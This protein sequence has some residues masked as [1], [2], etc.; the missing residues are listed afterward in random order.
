VAVLARVLQELRIN[1]YFTLLTFFWCLAILADEVGKG[2]NILYLLDFCLIKTSFVEGAKTVVT[3]EKLAVESA[4]K[5]NV[6]VAVFL[7]LDVLETLF[8]G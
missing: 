5:A 6:V 2:V 1:I 3:T 8:E 4:V 7:V